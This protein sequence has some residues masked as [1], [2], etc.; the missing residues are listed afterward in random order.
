MLG[1]DVSALRIHL[2]SLDVGNAQQTSQYGTSGSTVVSRDTTTSNHLNHPLVA[3]LEKGDI[4]DL[5]LQE[6]DIA[7]SNTAWKEGIISSF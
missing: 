6:V 1:T 5:I 3:S 4:V 2:P 7:D